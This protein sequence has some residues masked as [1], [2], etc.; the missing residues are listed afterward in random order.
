MASLEESLR[1][2]GN[3]NAVANTVGEPKG[4]ESLRLF[5]SDQSPSLYNLA[6][7]EKA[8]QLLGAAQQQYPY[9]NQHNFDVT[10]K[11][12]VTRLLGHAETFPIGETG[13]PD[14]PA[15]VG[16][17]NNRNRVEIYDPKFSSSDLA[18]EGLHVD[19]YSQQ[20]REAL[21]NSLSSYQ[22]KTLKHN[23]GD[24]EMSIKAKQSE[25]K[26]M[27][28]AVDSA[29]RGHVFNQDQNLVNEGMG[30]NPKQLKILDAL[31]NYAVTGN[32]PN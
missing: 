18:A 13:S 21:L 16:S 6:Q 19:P 29:L 7:A 23:A 27:E 9:L 24:Y 26:A 2:F 10:M 1:S 5:G 17:D 31:K 28:N 11:P 15:P 14:W 8:K 25:Q 30:Y 32:K 4:L 22:V 20:T 3:N 12:Q